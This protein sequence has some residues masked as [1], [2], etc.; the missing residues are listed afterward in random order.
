MDF[1]IIFPAI[2]VGN[3]ITILDISDN[4]GGDELSQL[5]VEMVKIKS[6]SEKFLFLYIRNN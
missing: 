5:L 1:S 3:N 6:V 2:N 4:N